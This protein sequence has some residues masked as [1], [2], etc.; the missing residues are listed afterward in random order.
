MF[1]LGRE[2]MLTALE[3]ME[4]EG[5]HHYDAHC[6]KCRRANSLSRDRLEQAYP[7]WREALKEMQKQAAKAEKKSVETEA[8]PSPAKAKA[9]AKSK[10]A[11]TPAAAAKA[12]PAPKGA[13]ST[14]SKAGIPAK[15]KST[16]GAK[17]K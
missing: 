5:L 17:T 15:K 4:A 12:R 8:K 7:G 3:Q 16:T 9:P 10:A 2:T 13:K 11:T 1:A 6:P 14:G